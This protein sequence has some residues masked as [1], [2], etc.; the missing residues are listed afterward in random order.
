MANLTIFLAK[1]SNTIDYSSLIP[2]VDLTATFLMK[3]RTTTTIIAEILDLASHRMSK[4]RIMYRAFLSH[5]QLQLYLQ[6]LT[7][8]GLI[9][10]E[11][12]GNAYRT[13]EKGMHFLMLY[14]QLEQ[15]VPNLMQKDDGML[16]TP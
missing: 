11:E 6:I 13:T 14:R 7:D 12:K 4:S 1:A 2:S 15:F 16:P 10:K 5:H 8:R 3:H 9:V